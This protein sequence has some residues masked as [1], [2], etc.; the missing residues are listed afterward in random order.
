LIGTRLFRI[1]E[2]AKTQLKNES[3]KGSQDDH[4]KGF[5]YSRNNLAPN[6]EQSRLQ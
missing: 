4:I 3:G 6:P 2:K 1:T 5:Y